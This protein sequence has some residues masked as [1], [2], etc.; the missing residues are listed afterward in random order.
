MTSTFEGFGLV[1]VE[2]MLFGCIPILFN[3]FASASD[4]INS[5]KNGFLI[6]PFHVKEYTNKLLNLMESPELIKE[7]NNNVIHSIEKFNLDLIGEQW[8]NLLNE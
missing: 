6:P 2:S 5:G 3:S 7:I 8:I 4:I 1:L